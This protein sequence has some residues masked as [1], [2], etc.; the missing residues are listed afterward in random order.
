MVP[1]PSPAFS[2]ESTGFVVN[3]AVTDFDAFIVSVH[4]VLL[5]MHAPLHAAKV[6]PPCGVAH[7]MDTG[8][9]RGV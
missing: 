8:E 3:V 1:A 9:S 6:D 7:G 4:L 5:P 2:T